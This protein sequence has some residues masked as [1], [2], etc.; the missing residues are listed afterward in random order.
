[1]V[2]TETGGAHMHRPEPG[3]ERWRTVLRTLG[4]VFVTGGL[5]VLLFVVHELFVTD[6]LTDRKQSELSQQLHEVWD[7][8]PVVPPVHESKV[9]NAFPVLHIPRSG[10]DY[11]R[12]VL[13]GTAEE[14]LS[15]TPNAAAD[16][17]PTG[18]YLTLTT[19]HPDTPRSSG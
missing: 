16:A 11:E 8:A 19:C 14:Q 2:H 5:V 13:E 12:V 1:M 18:A 10:P 6:L 4:E 9:G 17:A 7:R 15:P 3:P